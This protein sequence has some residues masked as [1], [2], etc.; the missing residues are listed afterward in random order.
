MIQIR[1]L[2]L[3]LRFGIIIS[4]RNIKLLILPV[5]KDPALPSHSVLQKDD[6]LQ[7]KV[8]E[9]AANTE[10]LDSEFERLGKFVKENVVKESEVAAREENKAHNRYLDIGNEMVACL[11]LFFFFS[12][13]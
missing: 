4:N 1:N 10:L 5:R 6:T 3:A 7:D 11:N 8:K 13:V 9:L 12:S 2:V